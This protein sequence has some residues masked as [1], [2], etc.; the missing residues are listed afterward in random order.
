MQSSFWQDYAGPL[1][2]LAAIVF[3][4]LLD[5]FI[6]GGLVRFSSRRRRFRVS[7]LAFWNP[8]AGA[9]TLELRRLGCDIV[10]PEQDNDLVIEVE[11]HKIR[12]RDRNSKRKMDI[13]V[14]QEDGSY[15]KPNAAAI[16]TEMFFDDIRNRPDDRLQIDREEY[17]SIWN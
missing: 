2:I 15:V 4:W 8:L 6:C 1:I 5:A 16:M 13:P 17:Y 11:D 3:G 14:V 12:I 9:A 10:G 7:N